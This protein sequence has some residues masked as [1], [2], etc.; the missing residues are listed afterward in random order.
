MTVCKIH[1]PGIKYYGVRNFDTL[2]QLS[3]FSKSD[4]EEMRAVG[5]VFPF[6]TN[7]YVVENLIDWDNVPDDPIFRLNFP[8]RDMLKPRE[9]G[10]MADLLARGA[11]KKEI[12]RHVGGILRRLNPHPAGQKEHNVPRL[13]QLP[14]PGIQHKYRETV[15]VFP[16]AGQSCHAYCSFCFRW[17]QFVSVSD[18]KFSA[19]DTDAALE[20]IRQK[21]DI[22]DILITGGDPMVMP[23]RLLARRVEPFL[24]PGFEHVQNIRI[25][26][27]SLSYWPFRYLTDP[28]ADDVIRLFEKIVQKNKHLAIMAHF[29]H[30]KELDTPFVRRAIG[31]IRSAGA[32]IRTQSPLVRHVNNSPGVWSRMWR[33]QVGLGCVPYY[34]FVARETGAQDYFEV[35]LVRCLEVFQKAIRNVSG[36]GRTVRGPVMSALP[37]KIL[38]DGEAEIGGEKVFVLSFLQGRNPDWQGR[39]FFARRC[40]KAAWISGLKPAFGDKSFFYEKELEQMLTTS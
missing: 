24:G 14:V 4:I 18:W 40:D 31:R 32:E 8:H 1:S 5:Q 11:S 29:N 33:M 25:G 28:D 38:V 3:R 6:R 26:T 21:K 10:M 27:K 9:L 12:R 16:P 2:P 17:P 23:A 30:W 39:P 34:M 7:P 22:T 35:P 20:Y 13:N 37:G 15:L 19:E 36:L